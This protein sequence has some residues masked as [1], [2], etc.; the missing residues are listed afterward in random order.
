MEDPEVT[1]SAD[2]GLGSSP[3]PQTLQRGRVSADLQQY[4]GQGRGDGCLGDL[5]SQ[6]LPEDEVST[7]QGVFIPPRLCRIFFFLI[8]L[9]ILAIS[10]N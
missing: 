6:G 4:R 5:R 3:T 7:H 8:R 10:Y 9:L 1:G 2:E